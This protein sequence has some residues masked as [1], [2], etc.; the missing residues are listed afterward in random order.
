MVPSTTA[1]SEEETD[2]ARAASLNAPIEAL[3]GLANAAVEAAAAPSSD[4][5]RHVPVV[6]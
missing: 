4:A 5:P 2:E 3:Q 6:E 1:S